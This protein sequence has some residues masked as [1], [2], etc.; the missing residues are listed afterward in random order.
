MKVGLIL[1][2]GPD[3]PDQQVCEYLIKRLDPEIEVK[4]ATMTGKPSLIE[5]CGKAAKAHFDDGCDR[6]VIVW[7]LSP[8]WRRG[9]PS[10][11]KLDREKI[12]ESLAK[13]G[14]TANAY[15]VCIKHELETWVLADERA[16]IAYLSTTSRAAEVDQTKFPEREPNPKKRLRQIFAVNRHPP[17]NEQIHAL[18]VISEVLDFNRLRRSASFK[19]FALK[20]VDRV[21]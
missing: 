21:V 12:L 1:E 16:L 18:S 11:R 13:A 8:S 9:E 4:S 20:A 5:N 6:V 10:C 14:V 3:G 17:F 2:C 15:L 7:D 19:R